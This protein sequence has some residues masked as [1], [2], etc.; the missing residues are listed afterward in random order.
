ASNKEA[1][2][3]SW[4]T[5]WRWP[6]KA[7]NHGLGYDVLPDLKVPTQLSSLENGIHLA[8]VAV[9][10]RAVGGR[11][12]TPLPATFAFTVHAGP[13]ARW[14]AVKPSAGDKITDNIPPVEL[15][16]GDDAK[17]CHE[18]FKAVV[19]G[20]VPV[21]SYG[22]RVKNLPRAPEIRIEGMPLTNLLPE[23]QCKLMKPSKEN[24][25]YHF[26]RSLNLEGPPGQSGHILIVASS[27]VD[28][29]DG[30][31]PARGAAA[32]GGGVDETRA[33]R[34]PVSIRAGLP[35]KLLIRSPSLGVKQFSSEIRAT[36]LSGFKVADLEVQLVDRNGFHA[37]L[38]PA[39]AR[40]LVTPLDSLPSE[41]G[42]GSGGLS[43]PRGRKPAISRSFPS[44]VKKDLLK[45][46]THLPQ[47][48]MPRFSLDQ[49]VLAGGGGGGG[50]GGEDQQA[51]GKF[52]KRAE[53]EKVERIAKE[54]VALLV[55]AEVADLVIAAATI[56]WTRQRTCAVT[57]VNLAALSP[58][59]ASTTTPTPPSEPTLQEPAMLG[60]V[61][62]QRARKTGIE[63]PADGP[64]PSLVVWLD[65]DNESPCDPSL[66]SIG[67]TI[68]SVSR[69]AGSRTQSN[70]YHPPVP[71]PASLGKAHALVFHPKKDVMEQNV[72]EHSIWCTYVERRSLV[73]QGTRGQ[74]DERVE[75]MTL[76]V[77]AGAPT[78]LEPMSD[79]ASLFHSLSASNQTPM[80]PNDDEARHAQQLVEKTFRF[81]A[82]DCRGNLAGTIKGPV[83]IRI[84]NLDGVDVP[85]SEM[86]RL[87]DS[88]ADGYVL[89]E[90]TATGV[91]LFEEIWLQSGVGSREA[92]YR[93]VVDSGG[94]PELQ[95]WSTTF[96]F[97]TDEKRLTSIREVEGRLKPL[98]DKVA[99]YNT[100]RQQASTEQE[101]ALACAKESARGLPRNLVSAIRLDSLDHSACISEATR[102]LETF[103]EEQR[104]RQS[105]QARP[106]KFDHGRMSPK[107]EDAIKPVGYIVELGYVKDD[108]RAKLMSHKAGSKMKAVYVDT[109]KQ[110]DMVRRTG[111][112]GFCKEVRTTA[113]RTA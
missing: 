65:T 112:G 64:L 67:F 98:K 44:S 62:G 77:V 74:E 50:G 21:D 109:K 37:R 93:L 92:D 43:S 87:E 40:L 34:L 88:E 75:E 84:E 73:T 17:A 55:R 45:R 52:S 72:G 68:A 13:V 49:K 33:L 95:P 29:A 99:Q 96:R 91:F 107:D 59:P 51:S 113:L 69:T 25:H 57:K 36:Q 14:M 105:Q 30:G 1:V 38:G 9:T 102:L 90:P 42:G 81:T 97:E 83:R 70:L 104:G 32:A 79:D 110:L 48:K 15:T 41:G 56:Y 76:R 10:P 78:K 100:A 6:S 31:G 53:R 2:T 23:H 11:P 86:P 27:G 54:G 28:S 47:M 7:A 58:P 3:C 19:Q 26:P 63:R 71:A 39:G 35:V 111:T 4:S 18:S 24:G 66:D 16:S 80:N 12:L 60:S 94:D 103:E 82:N 101:Q 89:A 5:A 61:I 108:Y 46:T 8:K 20:F 22:N 106:L 85:A